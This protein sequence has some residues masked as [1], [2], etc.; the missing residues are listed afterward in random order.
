M[1]VFSQVAIS[2]D[3]SCSVRQDGVA[4]LGASGRR[5][6]YSGGTGRSPVLG[7]CRT[8]PYS[9]ACTS[10]LFPAAGLANPELPALQGWERR[11]PQLTCQAVTAGHQAEPREWGGLCCP[12]QMLPPLVAP[13]QGLRRPRPHILRF[14]HVHGEDR[15]AGLGRGPSA[16][17]SV[18]SSCLL[19]PPLLRQGPLHSAHFNT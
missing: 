17:F 14:H 12:Q 18:P 15:E 16:E 2:T 19:C 10:L 9:P 3:S 4:G 5:G 11:Q 7:D 13:S 8:Q 6:V 1:T